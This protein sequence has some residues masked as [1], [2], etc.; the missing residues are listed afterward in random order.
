MIFGQPYG[1]HQQL[2][3]SYILKLLSSPSEA[4]QYLRLPG[5]GQ[6]MDQIA[7]M[8]GFALPDGNELAAARAAPGSARDGLSVLGRDTACPIYYRV[9]D[10]LDQGQHLPQ[11]CGVSRHVCPELKF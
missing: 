7:Q 2:Q 11:R 10:L 8:M 4:G 5:F 3:Q 6:S 9:G 1:I